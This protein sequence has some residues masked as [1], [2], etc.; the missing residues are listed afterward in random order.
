MPERTEHSNIRFIVAKGLPFQH[1][2]ANIIQKPLT[3]RAFWPIGGKK[4]P[5]AFVS[6]AGRLY[7]G[8]GGIRTHVPFRTT[9]FRVRLVA[10]TSI[11]LHAQFDTCMIIPKFSVH[12]KPFDSKIAVRKAKNRRAETHQRAGFSLFEPIPRCRCLPRIPCSYSA[13]S[14]PCS[15]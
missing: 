9:A 1:N 5:P 6:K 4:N 7:G 13:R 15:S 2:L 12:V 11:L 14:P 3:A 8:E 10:T